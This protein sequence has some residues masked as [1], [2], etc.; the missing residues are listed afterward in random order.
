MN[1]RQLL[2]RDIWDRAMA[3]DVFLDVAIHNRE[4]WHDLAR[5]STLPQELAPR[6]RGVRGKYRFLVL[7]EDWCGDAVNSVPYMVALA[8]ELP[9][10]ELRV[11]HR[12]RNAEVMDMYLSPKGARAIPVCVI[13][14]E[15]FRDPCWWGSRPTELQTWVMS[16]AAQ[17]MDKDTRYKHI[18]AWYARDRGRSTLDEIVAYLERIE[19][20]AKV[21]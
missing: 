1:E 15:Q 16:P 11:L 7:L 20:Q 2:L 6:L 9:G 4:L 18:R 3:F 21:A 14:D 17:A 8:A 12:D 10:S 13:L 5:R 19:K